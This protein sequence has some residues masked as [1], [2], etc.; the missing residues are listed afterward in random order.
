MVDL[1]K[2]KGMIAEAPVTEHFSGEAVGTAKIERT[3][4][5]NLIFHVDASQMPAGILRR[6]FSFD[7]AVIP[8]EG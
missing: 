1:E 4:G 5:N 7:K 8:G 3:R 2:P 6:G